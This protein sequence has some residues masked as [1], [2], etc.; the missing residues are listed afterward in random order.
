MTNEESEKFLR[1]QIGDLD[2][3]DLK[4]ARA[5]AEFEEVSRK[6]SFLF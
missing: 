6:I 1:E 2:D 3:D 5:N 4:V